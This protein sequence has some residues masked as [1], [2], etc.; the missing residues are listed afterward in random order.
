MRGCLFAFL[1]LVIAVV[2]IW[3]GLAAWTGSL[4]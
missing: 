3:W 1:F 4:G 2:L